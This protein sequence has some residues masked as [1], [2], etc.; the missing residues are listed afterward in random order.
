MQIAIPILTNFSWV[1]FDFVCACEEKNRPRPRTRQI[2]AW[3]LA[4]C[5]ERIT[6]P[7]NCPDLSTSLPPRDKARVI[8]VPPL[9][10]P[11]H[12]LNGSSSALSSKIF[13]LYKE[14]VHFIYEA[15]FPPEVHLLTSFGGQ[16]RLSFFPPD[17]GQC[18]K[19]IPYF[20]PLLLRLISTG[21]LG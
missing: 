17:F 14:Y 4:L 2:A 11:S 12:A 18:P 21:D 3:G 13:P 6:Q 20:S 9:S 19:S 1:C 15:E 5:G 7:R 10:L 8:A 16:C